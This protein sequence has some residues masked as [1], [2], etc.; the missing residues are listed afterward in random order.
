MR[1]KR[2][3]ATYFRWESPG[4]L[5]LAV[6]STGTSGVVRGD[7]PSGDP[8]LE[9]RQHQ[10]DPC[11]AADGR[12]PRMHIA[13]VSFGDRAYDREAEARAAGCATAAAVGAVEALEDPLAFGRRRSP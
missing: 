2:A 10:L 13:A 6:S 8:R 1:R 12:I 4:D 11:P 7:R 5:R 9:A 3:A